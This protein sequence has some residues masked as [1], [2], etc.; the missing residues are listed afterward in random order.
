MRKKLLSALLL[1][2]L[3]FAFAVTG[4]A[5]AM[6][7]DRYFLGM[8]EKVKK[9]E[10]KNV[11][12]AMMPPKKRLKKLTDYTAPEVGMTKEEAFQAFQVALEAEAKKLV[13]CLWRYYHWGNIRAMT[14]DEEKEFEQMTTYKAAE[15]GLTVVYDNDWM[16][17][18]DLRQ[19]GVS[20]EKDCGY[21][22]Y[23]DEKTGTIFGPRMCKKDGKMFLVG[24]TI[25]APGVPGRDMFGSPSARVPLRILQCYNAQ[26]GMIF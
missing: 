14:E 22:L 16:G 10:V 4:T 1:L 3:T 13:Y 5:R 12:R 23:I 25:V 24:M 17:K 21:A 6:D 18:D 9:E 11:V 15:K 2:F 8:M 19:M 7:P 20:K 26:E